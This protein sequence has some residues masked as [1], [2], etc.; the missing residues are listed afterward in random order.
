MFTT[1]FKV[2]LMTIYAGLTFALAYLIVDVKT[3]VNKLEN[4]NLT[5]TVTSVPT[6]TVV[7]SMSV[8]ATPSGAKS[9]LPLAK[10]SGK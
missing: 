2:V 7:P 4:A 1:K 6:T 10:P 8:T 5:P 3:Q 9:Q